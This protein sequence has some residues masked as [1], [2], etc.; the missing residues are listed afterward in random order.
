[1]RATVKLVLRD[2]YTR[3]D[4]KQQLVLLYIAHKQS[5]FIGLGISINPKHWDAKTL[6]VRAGDPLSAQYNKIITEVYQKAMSIVI[7]NYGRPL[8]KN[9]FREQLF[10]KSEE[11]ET[12]FYDFIESELE[13]LKVDRASGTIANYRKLLNTMKEWKATLTFQE[14]DLDFIEKFHTQEVNI[15]N[16]ESTINKKHANLKFLIGRAVLKEKMEKNP[17]ERFTIKKSIKAQN[18]D[19]LTELEVE[20]LYK[21]YLGKTYSGGKQDVLRNFLFSCYTALSYAEF[22][23]ITYADLKPYEINKQKCLLLC[24]ERT[25]NNMPYKIPIVSDKV[26]NLL[27]QGLDFQKIFTS[28]TNQVTNRYLKAIMKE[29]GINKKMTFHVARHSSAINRKS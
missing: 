18:N 26:K 15:G 20:K 6:M 11:V 19:T 25:K 17:Y 7:I 9:N 28:L 2:Y 27:K 14:I 24:N 12:N 21:V 23:V 22:E 10:E 13:V 29:Q 1:M 8:S 5:T 3:K 4:G 16:L